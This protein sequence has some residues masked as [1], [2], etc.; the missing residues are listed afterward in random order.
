LKYGLVLYYKISTYFEPQS[1][2]FSKVIVIRLALNI[3][4][5]LSEAKNNTPLSGNSKLCRNSYKQI[6]EYGKDGQARSGR[7]SEGRH[8]GVKDGNKQTFEIRWR[9]HAEAEWSG[10]LCLGWKYRIAY[11]T[12]FMH[13]VFSVSASPANGL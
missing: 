4:H 13:G 2:T 8:G 7:V 9:A 12:V 10:R 11:N 1:P 5:A 6:R 3:A